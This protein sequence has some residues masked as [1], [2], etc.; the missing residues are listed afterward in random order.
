[1]LQNRRSNS[2]DHTARG[3]HS[4]PSQ[5]RLR[6]PTSADTGGGTTSALPAE[7]KEPDRSRPHR[8]EQPP[9]S[10][11]TKNNENYIDQKACQSQLPARWTSLRMPAQPTLSGAD[12]RS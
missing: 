7:S 3:K 12:R 5:G 10:T 8:R 1:M 6:S 9:T 4:P 2:G 11:H